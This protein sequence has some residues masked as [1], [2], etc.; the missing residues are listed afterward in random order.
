VKRIYWGRFVSL[1]ALDKHF[2]IDFYFLTSNRP[3]PP[4]I[5]SFVHF[6]L[7]SELLLSLN[8]SLFQFYFINH[9]RFSS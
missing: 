5:G 7:S 3:P 6:L 4:P 1:F 8:R 2:V 9:N